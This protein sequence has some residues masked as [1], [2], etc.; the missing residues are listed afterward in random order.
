MQPLHVYMG[1][2]IV[3]YDRGGCIGAAACAAVDPENFEMR[4]DGLAWLKEGKETAKGS[5]VFTKEVDDLGFLKEAA[6]SC[7]VQVIKVK[8][9]NTNRYVAP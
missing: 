9:K 1:E 3:E 7:P 4:E 2:Y 6:E 8:V 5:N